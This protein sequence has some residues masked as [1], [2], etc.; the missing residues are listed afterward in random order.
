[1]KKKI[2]FLFVSFIGIFNFGLFSNKIYNNLKI[3]Y[4]NEN[5]YTIEVIKKNEIE[6][7]DKSNYIY[8]IES[9]NKYAYP[10]EGGNIYFDLEKGIIFDCDTTV[11]KV[12]I[13]E[14]INNVEVNEIAVKTFYECSK[15]SDIQ[16]PETLKV[17]NTEAFAECKSL[18]K[19]KIPD[20][21]TE[22]KELAFYNSSIEEIELS[23]NISKID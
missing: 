3:A 9:K 1:M 2:V 21:V 7:L 11:T 17:I 4:A 23:K 13:P 14:K 6:N 16:M 10:A 12:I 15:L 18:K 22:I 8:P 19:I 5:N 20:S